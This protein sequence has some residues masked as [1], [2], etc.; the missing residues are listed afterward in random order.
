M[1]DAA[2]VL[3]QF[4]IK[5]PAITIAAAQQAGLE[6]A[7]ACAMLMA[8]SSGGQMIWGHDGAPSARRTDQH[9]AV[10]YQFG[11]P[12]T[13]ANYT[14]YRA[15]QRAG[16]IPRQGIGD[17]QLT[18]EEFVARAERIGPGPWDPF[19]NQLAGFIGMANRIVQYGLFGGLKAYNGSGPAAIRY[20]NEL[21]AQVTAW[22]TH[23]AG[24]TT[25]GDDLTPEQAQQLADIHDRVCRLETAWGGGVTD[26]NNTPY[27]MR[28]LVDRIDVETHQCRADVARLGA[29]IAD[30]SKA[31]QKGATS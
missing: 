20:A 18:S 3:A 29:L 9:G 10:I 30:L 8:E 7:V 16:L 19:C 31:V 15:A 4:G 2:T 26:A 23:L 12:V 11:G 22:R 24:A 17:A 25:E 1:T 13:Q 21:F 28:L 14:A 27:D 6:L 5:R